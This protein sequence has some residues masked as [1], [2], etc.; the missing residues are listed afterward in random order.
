[1]LLNDID[2]ECLFRMAF[3]K[4]VSCFNSLLTMFHTKFLLYRTIFPARDKTNSEVQEW[5]SY[6]SQSHLA[7]EEHTITGFCR[8]KGFWL[9]VPGTVCDTKPHAAFQP[10][11]RRCLR[12]C[13]IKHMNV[14]SHWSSLHEKYNVLWEESMID[15]PW[16]D[17][18]SDKH[19]LQTLT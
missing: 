3:Y 15:V 12:C 16:A 7:K 13:N 5:R 2:A 10:Q 4:A 14:Q 8:S 6:R 1:M 18:L 11:R 19:I 17:C 9:S